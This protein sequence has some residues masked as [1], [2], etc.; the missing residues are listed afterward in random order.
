MNNNVMIPIDLFN[1]T[2]DLLESFDID[3][4][5]Y[6]V[7]CLYDLVLSE[8]HKKQQALHLRHSYAR[9]IFAKDGDQ[10]FDAR[11][12]YLQQKRSSYDCR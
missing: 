6:P 5:D 4:L 11:L 9:I 12:R 2:L 7:S 8:F 10:R 1:N 3:D